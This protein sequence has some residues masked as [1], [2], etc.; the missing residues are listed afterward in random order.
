MTPDTILNALARAATVPDAGIRLIDRRERATWL[1]WS[2]IRKRAMATA[3]GLC[4]LG[5]RQGDR[6]AVVHPTGEGFLT[7]FFGTI[8]AGAIPVPLY[9]PAR[10]GGND[11][12]IES[13]AAMVRAVAART[14]LIDA[15]ARTAFDPAAGATRTELGVHTL[16]E[17]PAGRPCDRGTTDPDDIALVQFSSGSTVRPK[18]VALSHR[19]VRIQARTLNQLWPGHPERHTGVSWLPL[20]HDMG[21]IGCLFPALELPTVLTLLA[22]ESFVARPAVWLRTISR[23]RATVSPAPNFAFALATERIPDAQME[24][25]DL[26]SWL[27]APNGAEPIAPDVLRAFERRFANWGLRRETLTPVYGLSEAA[28]AV[29]FSDPGR[30]YRT[31]RFD[32][33]QLAES[34][35][36]VPDPSGTELV[37]VGRPIPG[38]ELRIVADDGTVVRDGHVGRVWARGPSLLTAYLGMPDETARALRDGWLD[39]GDLGFIDDG[40]LFL[41]GR[42]KDVVILRG[43]NYD[44][45]GF[46][47]AAASVPDIRQGRVVAAGRRPDRASQE[48]L[49]LFAEPRVEVRGAE[50]DR[51]KDAC[52]TA[53]LTATGVVPD[54]IVL[55]ARGAIP[56]TSSGKVRR[57]ETVRRF[58]CGVLP[59]AG[60]VDPERSATGEPET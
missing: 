21:L 26:T 57:G 10:I 16:D 33:R 60:S 47:A 23:Y 46:E 6:V 29:T 39:T 20:Y 54:T 18:P 1:P 43:R 49:W 56:R 48:G 53:V 28:L 35:R 9:P 30:P 2:A 42:A 38:V 32:R 31:R 36:A 52:R 51:L 37:S 12:Y 3:G 22:P 19:A 55:V 58:E 17:L 5:V 50:R 27:V 40:E 41:T 13:T 44:P 59:L 14:A 11:E 15:R 8:A 34:R 45:A 25:V 4:T 7:A 24:G